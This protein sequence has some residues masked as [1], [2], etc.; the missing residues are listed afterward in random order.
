[1]PRCAEG[2]DSLSV[3][4]ILRDHVASLRLSPEQGKAAAHI[5]ACRTGRLG[6][7]FAVCD[8]CGSKHFAYDSCRDRHCPRCGGL[9]QAIWA[10]AQLQHLLPVSYYHLVPT[11]PLSL[12]PFF[13]GEG[14]AHAFDA[15]FAAVS[16]TILE[17]AERMGVCLGVLAVLHTWTQLLGDHPHIHC[18]VPGG[19][20][21]SEGRFVLMPRFLMSYRRLR[22]VFKIKLLQKLR[23]LVKEGVLSLGRASAY[24]LLDDAD[25]REWNLKVKRAMRGPEEVIRYFARY[26]RRIAISD[27]RLV[28]YDGTT[29]TFRYRDRRNG[30]RSELERVDGRTFCRRFL[31]HVLP[32]RFV[33]IRRYGILS[34]RSRE[35]R[36]KAAR[37]ALGQEAPPLLTKES[38]SAACLRIF[39]EDPARCPECHEG[40]L[41]TLVRWTAT[42]RPMDIVRAELAA[43]AP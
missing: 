9:D 41:V 18:L 28:S 11:V 33:R 31:N 5:M 30:N 35:K 24:Q 2:A 13:R 21:D 39:G 22:V 40:R 34:N 10:E 3:A 15:L 38:R 17:V 16:E 29:V 36:L 26:T 12:R 1:M 23:R 14:R 19:G 4:T 8:R 27:S 7:H 37:D 25:S 43:R 6:G 32:Q 42:I 20:F